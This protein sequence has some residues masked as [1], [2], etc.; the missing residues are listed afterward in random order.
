M[1][2]HPHYLDRQRRT[3]AVIDVLRRRAE[4]RRTRGQLVPQVLRKAIEDYDRR[5][6][7]QRP[8]PR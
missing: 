8:G 5:A 3:E 4:Q 6:R 7:D 2:A 1:H